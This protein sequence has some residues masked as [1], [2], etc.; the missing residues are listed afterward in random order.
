[1]KKDHV[2]RIV[3]A[4]GIFFLVYQFA[5][6]P[7]IE[8]KKA[9]TKE[10]TQSKIKTTSGN[11][12]GYDL[13]V[14]GEEPDGI[15]AAVSAARLGARTLLLAN[16][17]NLGGVFSHCLLTSLEIP[18][19]KDNA[20][21]N[22]GFLSELETRLGSQFSPQDYLYIVNT[23]VK[24]EKNIEV[25]Y[26][27][28]LKAVNIKN[29]RVSSLEITAGDKKS[30]VEGSIFIDASENGSLLTAC[31][32][33]YTSGSED[34]NLKNSY[35]PVRLNFEMAGT[36]IKKIRELL[37]NMDVDFYKSLA[38]YDPGDV[39]ARI[40]SFNIYEIDEKT[41]IVQGVELCNI[42]VLNARELK[43]AYSTANEEAKNLAT[44]LAN[45]FDQFKGWKYIGAAENLYINEGKHF[46]GVY[47]LTV[48]DVLS[49]TWF[50]KTVAMGSYP[51]QIGKFA[52]KSTLYAGKPE[53]YAVPLGCM[54]PKGIDNLF[55]TG[56][57][58]SYSS[59]AA[60]SAGIIGTSIV[61]G[62]SAGVLSAFCILNS[63]EP[64]DIEKESDLGKIE[65]MNE[66][67]VKQG[68]N[69]PHEEFKNKLTSNWAYTELD[70][71]V[72]L[73]LVAGGSNND[74]HLDKEAV[75]SDFAMLLLNG[76]YRVAPEKYSLPLDRRIRPYFN[77]EKLTPDKAARILEELYDLPDKGK[78]SY[79]KV[80]KLGYINKILQLSIKN[81][82]VLTMDEVYYL[83]AYII[84]AYTSKS[85][86]D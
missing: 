21:L 76:I 5:F 38:E 85:I 63:L 43:L 26:G 55:M 27:V 75:Q 48:N 78:N 60:S 41:I 58:I 83:S 4:I 84:K 77:K 45:R 34:L 28:S 19:G 52:G 65:D 73:G 36:D 46:K 20:K 37:K 61:T 12:N 47:T 29:K 10:N 86:P 81:K 2:F 9:D 79:D 72:S 50:D 54:I 22:A 80:C 17:K 64:S 67:L 3:L 42:N 23:I 70:Q 25:K 13:I 40:S 56:K 59:L 66:F 74:Y 32:I 82:E 39:N 8:N 24:N 31:D 16:G 7:M 57:K 44:F 49:N 62:N 15:A 6:K 71:L 69:F 11:G 35:M 68:L 1:M 51:I 18:Y 30:T 14:Y 33:P 53:Q